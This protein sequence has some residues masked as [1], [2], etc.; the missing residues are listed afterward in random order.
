MKN[1]VKS[2]AK[3][4]S[5]GFKYLQKKF[6]NV[7]EAKLRE[8]IFVG[9]QIRELLGDLGFEQALTPLELNAWLAF[10]WLSANILGNNKAPQYKE[11]VYNLIKSYKEMGCHMSHKI[12][13]LHSNLDFFPENLKAVSDEQGE[14]FH[15]DIKTMETRYQGSWNEN[16]MADHC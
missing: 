2:M 15:K 11:G 7:S 5:G 3:K 10:K 13:F 4:N 9:P 1:F 12:H 14:H 16:M 8:G 6:P